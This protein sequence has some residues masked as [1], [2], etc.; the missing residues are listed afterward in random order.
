MSLE[1]HKGPAVSLGRVRHRLR[2]RQFDIPLRGRNSL[3]GPRHHAG[4]IRHGQPLPL[5]VRGAFRLACNSDV[6]VLLLQAVQALG[7]AHDGSLGHAE[8][9]HVGSAVHQQGAPDLVGPKV[10][11]G[12]TAQAGFDPSRHH[13]G[14]LAVGLA[15]KVSIHG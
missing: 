4:E 10:V 3:G 5:R 14:R 1:Q 11:M 15:H 9:Q 12:E 6:L 13:E 7:D 2:R 8:D